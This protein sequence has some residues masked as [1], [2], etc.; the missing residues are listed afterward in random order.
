L[1]S[2]DAARFRDDE[3]G[4]SDG[5]GMGA[6]SSARNESA[7]KGDKDKEK[8]E[9]DKEDRDEGEM[10][11]RD[12]LRLWL[13]QYDFFC[14]NYQSFRWKLFFTSKNISCHYCSA[15][16][17]F[18]AIIVNCFASFPHLEGFFC[19]SFDASIHRLKLT[20][21]PSFLGILFDRPVCNKWR[22]DTHPGSNA[23]FELAQDRGE[24]ASYFLEVSV[25]Q[26]FL[27]LTVARFT[28]SEQIVFLP[29]EQR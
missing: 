7:H 18:G 3:Y 25:S 28:N 24:E 9:K 29:R 21:S 4:K 26:S 27:K 14:R 2:G 20:L 6:S 11:S 8:K 19:E 16:M 15:D 5:I 1:S 13:Q 23:C 17:H 22:R 10:T 12:I